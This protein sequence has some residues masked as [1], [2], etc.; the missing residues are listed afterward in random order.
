MQGGRNHPGG[1]VVVAGAVM[2]LMIVS[3]VIRELGARK[4]AE[5][6]FEHRRDAE[7]LQENGFL[8]EPGKEAMAPDQILVEAVSKTP[9]PESEKKI[10][11]SNCPR[12]KVKMIELVGVVLLVFGIGVTV[13]CLSADT[14]HNNESPFIQQMNAVRDLTPQDL[15]KMNLS[16]K[17][18]EQMHEV[19]NDLKRERPSLHYLDKVIK[20]RQKDTVDAYM[21]SYRDRNYSTPYN[22]SETKQ[23]DV[24]HYCDQL[25]KINKTGK[26]F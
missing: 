15:E 16:P 18:K 7:V 17:E 26:L 23:L 2:V 10:A 4:K 21:K 19:I 1:L 11:A 12:K 14:K 24:K 25:E 9:R 20:E 13:H 22:P 5:Q 6:A 8:K 3:G